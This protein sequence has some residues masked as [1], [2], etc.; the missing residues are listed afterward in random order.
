MGC[1]TDF[2]DLLDLAT[3][4]GLEC[5]RSISDALGLLLGKQGP[6]G[7]WSVEGRGRYRD[8][9]ALAGQDSSLEDVGVQSKWITLTALLVLRRCEAFLA[10]APPTDVCEEAGL[11]PDTVLSRYPFEYDPVDEGRV[12][13]EYAELR[14]SSVLEAMLGFAKQHDLSPAWH[15][16]FVMAPTPAR[17]G[18]H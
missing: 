4:I 10:G 11:P 18:V 2:L 7:R 3:Q 6:G 13:D 12:R 15:W 14:M 5:D 9:G 17:N 1:D 16:G 8:K